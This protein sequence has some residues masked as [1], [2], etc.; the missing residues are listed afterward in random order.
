MKNHIFKLFTIILSVVMTFT[1]FSVD[2]SAATA[3]E[4]RENIS[5]LESQSKK[6]ESEI[7]QLQGKINSQQQV[8]NKLEQ[9]ISIVQQQINA[10]NSKI[11]SINAAIA[12]NKAEIDKNNEK[13]SADKLA[14]KKRLR[15][16]HTSNSSGNLQ[17]LLGA[18]D[19]SQFL[20]LAQY[21]SSVSKRDKKL[22]DTLLKNIKSLEEK[23]EA[24]NKLLEEQV[25]IKQTIAQ[26]RS[27]LQVENNRIQQIINEIDSDQ[28]QLESDNK[29]IE[30]QIEAYNATL[31]AMTSTAGTSFVYDGGNFIWPTP[32]F[33]MISAGFKSNDAVHK[34]RHNGIDIAGGGISGARIVAISDGIVTRSNNSCTHN[35]KKS[36]SCGCGGGYG[37]Y[38]TIN[39]GTNNGKTFVAT[40]GHMSSTAV[41]AGTT[42][43]KGQT[44]GYVGTTGWSTGYHLHF[45][46]AVNGGWVNPMNYFRKVG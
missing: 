26:K 7:K 6:L 18:D 12:E 28:S 22:I 30:K 17:I 25:A 5:N 10:C 13:I 37:N 21:T 38:V 23:Q 44:I 43:K 19:F 20:Q 9:K 46:L 39:H 41:S 40:Y 16:I 29:K 3:A 14:Y 42:V 2:V 45:G 27:E 34:G 4:L 33:Y 8:K 31:A 15:A 35:Y 24:N 36:G 32:G 1:A 11:S